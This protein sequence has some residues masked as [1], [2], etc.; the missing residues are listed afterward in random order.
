MAVTSPAAPLRLDA[1]TFGLIAFTVVAWA[2]AFPAIRAGLESYGPLELGSARFAVAALPAAIYLLVT[3]PKLPA[4]GELWRFGYGGA[5]F[6][7]AYT[8][9]L[10]FGEL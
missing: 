10:N 2:S 6:V 5:F 1:G 4:R 9:L 7:A 8:V 3:R